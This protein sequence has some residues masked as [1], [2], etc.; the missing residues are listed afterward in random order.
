MKNSPK[1]FFLLPICGSDNAEYL[2]HCLKSLRECYVP[3]EFQKCVILCIDGSLNDQLWYQINLY[4]QEDN[5]C[6][7]FNNTKRSGLAAN[8][9]NAIRQLEVTKYDFFLRVDSDDILLT[10]RILSQLKCFNEHQLAEAVCSSVYVIDSNNVRVGHVRF[11]DRLYVPIRRWSNKLIHPAMMLR[12][13]FFNKYGLY[14]E[15]Y[16]YAQD[17]ELWMRASNKGAIFQTSSD[18][19]LE[20]R[21]LGSTVAKRKLT[22]K[23]CIEIANRYGQNIYQRAVIKLRSFAII[24]IPEFALMLLA[25]ML[26]K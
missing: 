23:Y 25:T 11:Q 9:N 2:R 17:W 12:G 16:Q 8:L 10:N 3:V 6:K 1:V 4:L 20:Y 14:D 22:Q 5:E 18:Y 7:L 15:D 21:F 19:V 26:R 24:S 13:D